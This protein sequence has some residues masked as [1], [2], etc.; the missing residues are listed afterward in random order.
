MAPRKEKPAE[1]VKLDPSAPPAMPEDAV[2]RAKAS[3]PTFRRGGV[4]FNDRDWT[5]LDPALGSAA[6]AAILAD[7]VLT[8]QARLKDGGWINLS[9]EDREKAIASLPADAETGQAQA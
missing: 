3:R 9:A 7:P 6:V 4:V 5:S 2:V 1:P 8:V